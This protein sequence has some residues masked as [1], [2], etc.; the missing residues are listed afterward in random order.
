MNKDAEEKPQSLFYGV[1]I[2]SGEQP[3]T[4]T[5]SGQGAKNRVIEI[6]LDNIMSDKLAREIHRMFTSKTRA[7]YGHF[8]RR[9]VEYVSK[10]ENLSEIEKNFYHIYDSIRLHAAKLNGYQPKPNST[11]DDIPDALVG[12]IPSHLQML[13]VF[14][15]GLYTFQS[16]LYAGNFS[17]IRK[18]SDFIEE[19]IDYAVKN[20]ASSKITTNGE[21]VLND[22]VDFI[23]S[24][25]KSFCHQS[26][27]CNRIYQQE[28]GGAANGI[29]LADGRVAIYGKVLRD[30]IVN[31]LGMSYEAV[32]AEWS[33]L[34]VFDEGASSTHL[35]Q[36]CLKIDDIVNDDPVTKRIWMFVVR[37]D[38]RTYVEKLK[39]EKQKRALA[40]V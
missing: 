12:I 15:T 17:K 30:L 10:G 37:K 18:I 7:T 32:I 39:R 11:E 1:R 16:V 36:K 29:K 5:T 38:V 8:G 13:S 20:F 34:G 35:H 6:N 27:D 24:E 4:S 23:E 28:S 21:R 26:I 22:L 9:Y 33:D 14:L 3:I 19:D 31:R 2:T 40:A 25:D